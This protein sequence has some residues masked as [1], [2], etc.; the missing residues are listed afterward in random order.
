MTAHAQGHPT[1]HEHAPV[2]QLKSLTNDGYGRARLWLGITGVGTLVV[3]A[4]AG[5]T[6]LQ[7]NPGLGSLAPDI[8]LLACFLGCY[9]LIQL[10][11]DVLG[12]YAVPRHFGRPHPPLRTF[13]RGWARGV[14]VHAVLLMTAALGLMLATRL[15]GITGALLW[16]LFLSVGLLRFRWLYAGWLASLRTTDRDTT[17]RWAKA[18]DHGFT[19]GLDGILGLSVNTVPELWR[20]YLPEEQLRLVRLRRAEA[21]ASGLFFRGR[22][23]AILFTLT[24]VLAASLVVGSE[25]MMTAAG[26]IEFSLLFTLWSFLGL[27][28]LPSVSRAAGD[29]LDRR[30]TA[31][32]DDTTPALTEALNNLNQLQDAETQRSGLVETVF[33][34]IRSPSR[35]Q[36]NSSPPRFAGWDAARTTVYLSA[37]GI[38]LLGRAVHCNVGRPSLWAYLPSE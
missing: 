34:P 4:T 36:T 24:G 28:I 23:I 6:A 7:L 2:E 10:P 38:S 19:G 27:L 5:L 33:H 15:M 31:S 1:T 32:H 37:A 25:S 21:K 29:A 22:L 26:V 12:G 11:F 8:V 3:T 16:A 17:T 30:L 13:I 20:S 18:A 35:R 9:V 14:A